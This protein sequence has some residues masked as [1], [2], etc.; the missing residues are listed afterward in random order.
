MSDLADKKC[1]PCE[2]GTEPLS[3]ERARNLL[4]QVPGWQVSADGLAIRREFSFKG[5]LSTMS[6]IIFPVLLLSPDTAR[7]IDFNHV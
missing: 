7:S 2:G 4:E 5:F 1:A 3:A 6:F